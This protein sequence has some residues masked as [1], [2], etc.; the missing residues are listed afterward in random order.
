MVA[1]SILHGRN[2]WQLVDYDWNE[3]TGVATLTYEREREDFD[4]I[5]TKVVT[6]LQ[7]A[8][9]N[10]IGWLSARFLD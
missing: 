3:S 6:K 7:P 8:L 4:A 1:M 5:E 9:P 2:G 10:H